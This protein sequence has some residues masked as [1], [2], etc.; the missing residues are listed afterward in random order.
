MVENKILEELFLREKPAKILMGLKSSK[1][2][3]YATTLSKEANCTYSHTTKILNEFS[4]LGLVQFDKKGR[5]KHVKLT[6][7][8][9]D[10]AHNVEAIT[11]KFLQIEE[12]IKS[13]ELKKSTKKAVVVKEAVSPKKTADKI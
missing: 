3:V 8:G 5:I 13:K 9:W 2:A 10:I 12:N 1:E 7:D 4:R 11:K 6:D